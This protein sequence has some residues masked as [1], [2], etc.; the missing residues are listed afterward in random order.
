MLLTIDRSGS[1]RAIIAGALLTLLILLLAFTLLSTR[2]VADDVELSWANG[3][4][5]LNDEV[6]YR[7]TG[8][9]G[10]MCRAQRVTLVGTILP[11]DQCVIEGRDLS[12]SQKINNVRVGED[13]SFYKITNL[14]AGSI[15][16]TKRDFIPNTN[17]MVTR[18]GYTM[19]TYSAI[20]SIE[21]N[22]LK[23]LDFNKLAREYTYTPSSN[24]DFVLSDSN[25]PLNVARGMGYSKNGRWLVVELMGM[26]LARIDL[27]NDFKAELFSTLAPSYYYGSNPNM[28]FAIS[29]EGDHVA[30]GG[31]NTPFM[32]FQIDSGCTK[33]INT[34]SQLTKNGYNGCAGIWLN[35]VSGLTLQHQYPFG[36]EFGESEYELYFRTAYANRYQCGASSQESCFAYKTLYAN[37]YNEP[38]KQ[39]S[40]L[41][42]GDSFSSGEGDTGKDAL[43]LTYYTPVTDY[44]GGCHLS[45]RSYP[46][47]LRD[48][49]GIAPNKMQS[50]ACSGAQ[51]KD[52]LVSDN[53]IGQG[54][55]KKDTSPEELSRLRDR[56]LEK[57]I[58]G[59]IEQIRFVETYKPK[60]LTIT[61][62][63]NDVGFG[64]KIK[65]CATSMGESCV[66]SDGRYRSE[67]A[68]H[69]YEL[70][71]QFGVL[72]HFYEKLHLASED[73]K[74]FVLGYP[75]FLNSSG[76]RPCA[77]DAGFMNDEELTFVDES[78]K[79]FNKI[80]QSAA[81]AAGAV[82][83]DMERSLEGG[84]ICD[85]GGGF[86]TGVV[87]VRY[88]KY[89]DSNIFHP[90]AAG[91]DKMYQ[92][93]LQKLGNMS[94]F[95]YPY[96]WSP[97]S[98]ISAPSPTPYFELPMSEYDDTGARKKDM[99]QTEKGTI[100][101]I[102]KGG[103][104]EFEVRQFDMYPGSTATRT[105]Y[106]DPIDIGDFIVDE[107]GGYKDT[108][109][110]P[111]GLSPGYHTLVVRGETYS[112][113]PIEYYQIILVKGK[114]PEDIDDNGVPDNKQVCGPFMFDID[115]SK[116]GLVI[117]E[118][119]SEHESEDNKEDL[120]HSDGEAVHIPRPNVIPPHMDKNTRGSGWMSS[121]PGVLYSSGSAGAVYR[122]GDVL[123][124]DKNPESSE[125][126]EKRQASAEMHNGSDNLVLVIISLSIVAAILLY[127]IKRF[128]S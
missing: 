20:L 43:G 21:K 45:V 119:E 51:V 112:G 85:V 57:F 46:F 5:V 80:I 126:R 17:M 33:D 60:V 29:D 122:D 116:C 96:T 120:D 34:Q 90:N 44:S 82:Y 92:N 48:S 26:G 71:R 64:E 98:S 53:Y 94:P 65:S 25:G 93:V 47:K 106:S 125:E 79:Y 76:G 68:K 4:P 128:K 2:T 54:D 123:Y 23:S 108:F 124:I 30:V 115:S 1:R 10:G 89:D 97:N 81:E 118:K 61:M 83:I 40:Y 19:F 104:V 35:E 15:V 52:V 127:C 9:D 13:N 39:I 111:E 66:F 18:S 86:V 24:P 11:V 38:V 7:K 99:L 72:K 109:V 22:L 121:V 32:L 58:P 50:V 100:Y 16:G 56:A 73:T 49:Q 36:L 95:E 70:Q 103:T 14:D 84:R 37:G 110:I 67:Q 77:L 62:G 91:H 6:K 102:E 31:L 3:T 117:D 59:Y 87:E 8:L 113:E 114:N 105:L 27:A 101:D 12:V 88:H 55:R 69:G 74:I 28:T 63:G 107:N 41:A 75:T 42:L 78:V